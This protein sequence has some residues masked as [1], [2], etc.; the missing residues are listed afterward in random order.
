V[1]LFQENSSP[2]LT[3]QLLLSYSRLLLLSRA[4]PID[5]VMIISCHAHKSSRGE[6]RNLCAGYQCFLE[7]LG[8]IVFSRKQLCPRPDY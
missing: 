4:G 5:L 1:T 2:F 3:T 8:Q 6:G 7:I